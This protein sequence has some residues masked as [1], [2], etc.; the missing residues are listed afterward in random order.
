MQRPLIASAPP[1]AHR[2][3]GW[4]AFTYGVL[5]ATAATIA[6]ALGYDPLAC[7]AWLGTSGVAAVVSSLVLGVGVAW[8][9]VRAT[10]TVAAR[11]AWARALHADLRPVVHGQGDGALL[12]MAVASGL[13]EELIFRGLLTPL[14]G[15]ALSSLAF[16]LMHQMRGRARWAWT[17]W[18]TLMGFVFASLFCLTGSLVGPIA[19]HVIVNAV[20]LRYLRDIDPAAPS[21]SALGG[22]LSR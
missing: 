10:R 1:D 12:L 7:P 18:A 22:L 19:A 4:V 20:N 5:G 13:A 6:A 2:A 16:G 11:A 15:V 14:L 8:V 17:L 21:T 3:G 9:T